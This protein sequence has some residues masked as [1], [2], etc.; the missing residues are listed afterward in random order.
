MLGC[1][2]GETYDAIYR[3]LRMDKKKKKLRYLILLTIAGIF[4]GLTFLFCF[5]ILN[6]SLASY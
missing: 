5:R 3:Q 6:R 2:D 4:K 1:H